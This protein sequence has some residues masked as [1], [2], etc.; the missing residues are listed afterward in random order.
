MLQLSGV[1]RES[2][3]APVISLGDPYAEKEVDDLP[4]LPEPEPDTVINP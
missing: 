1:V 4:I 3:D 2:E